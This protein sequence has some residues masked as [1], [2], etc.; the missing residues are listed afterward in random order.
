MSGLQ[1]TEQPTAGR[2]AVVTGVVVM[3]DRRELVQRQVAVAVSV[4]G[5]KAGVDVG[6]RTPEGPLQQLVLAMADPTV[7]VG[8]VEGEPGLDCWVDELVEPADL[9]KCLVQRR[10]EGPTTHAAR[11][12]DLG[13][14]ADARPEASA[15]V[16]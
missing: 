5:P 8:V 11:L 6:G 7:P 14:L 2:V 15:S 1:R 13:M 16:P 3:D 9:E 10:A 4:Y 12:V